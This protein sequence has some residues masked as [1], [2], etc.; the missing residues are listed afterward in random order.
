MQEGETMR[1][2]ETG[3]TLGVSARWRGDF[4][5]TEDLR[6]E[7]HFE[8]SIHQSNGLVTIG[9]KAHV[10]AQISVENLIVLGSVE[11]DIRATGSVVLQASA[12]V[13]GNVYSRRFSM[14]ADAVLRGQVDPGESTAGLEAP[15][16]AAS[17]SWTQVARPPVVVVTPSVAERIAMVPPANTAGV[18]PQVGVEESQTPVL[19][20][21]PLFV[22]API[23]AVTRT[24]RQLPTALAAF[25]AGGR[26]DL[27]AASER[28]ESEA[29]DNVSWRGR[30][31]GS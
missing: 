9:A 17:E 27:E 15:R 8:G 13:V 30:V 16:N 25:A 3:T 2:G 23:S 18:V 4:E 10:R 11:G 12:V 6:I 31:Q 14:E 1:A 7:G 19:P 26:Q 28:A 29:P 24:G 22:D 21:M 20:A 5:C